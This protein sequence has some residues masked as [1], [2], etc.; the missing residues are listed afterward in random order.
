MKIK[1]YKF[2]GIE[3]QFSIPEDKMYNDER[4]KIM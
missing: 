2:A 4:A 3:F 1:N